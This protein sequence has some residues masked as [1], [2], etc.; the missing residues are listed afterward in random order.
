[1]E[2]TL[3]NPPRGGDSG[4]LNKRIVLTNNKMTSSNSLTMSEFSPSGELEGVS[5]IKL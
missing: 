1:M 4:P 3:P 2:R 5:F